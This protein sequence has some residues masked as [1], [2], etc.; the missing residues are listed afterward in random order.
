MIEDQVAFYFVME[1]C[2]GGD[3]QHYLEACNEKR[4]NELPEPSVAALMRQ[5]F[6]AVHYLH[7]RSIAHSDMA[8]RNVLLLRKGAEASLEQC[9]A[10]LAE[11]R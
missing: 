11:S 8:A 7:E 2:E 1:L 9:S 4:I 3:L 6:S 10:K 5:L